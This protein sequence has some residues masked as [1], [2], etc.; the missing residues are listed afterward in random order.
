MLIMF[1]W[2][3]LNPL[4]HLIGDIWP[5]SIN[6]SSAA[7]THGKACGSVAVLKMMSSLSDMI[8]QGGKRH[9]ANMGILGIDHPEIIDFICDTTPEKINKYSPGKHIPIKSM[10]HFYKNT[11]DLA[12]LFA[13][14]HKKEIFEKEKEF[15]KKGKWIA[16]VEL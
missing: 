10:E 7:T 8:T 16:H 14:N 15:S 6:V 13:W 2:T 3:G 12:F 11:P 4:K 1:L 9:G 5:R